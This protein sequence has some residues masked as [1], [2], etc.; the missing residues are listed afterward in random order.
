MLHFSIYLS[1]CIYIYMCTHLSRLE[2]EREKGGRLE[3]EVE[4]LRT[5]LEMKTE[6]LHASR[7]SRYSV[8]YLSIRV[9]I[10]LSRC[11]SIYQGIYLS[12]Y[13]SIYSGIYLSIQVSIY[14]SGYLSI[15]PSIYLSIKVSILS[16]TCLL[17]YISTSNVSK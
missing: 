15:Y 11:L 13:L 2:A 6:E 8:I 9:Y 7:L 12:G 4:S 16:I 17:I 10:Y 1:L 3:Q 5:V 14:L